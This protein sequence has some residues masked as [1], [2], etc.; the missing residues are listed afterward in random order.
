MF[1][2]LDGR[3]W[4]EDWRSD[5]QTIAGLTK[6]SGWTAF[7]STGRMLGRLIIPGS[8]SVELRRF[9]VGFGK[10][11]VIFNRLDDDGALHYTAYRSR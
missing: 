11:E 9:V 6:P 2:D 10:D 4:V 7:D 1:V 8:A 3:L 5:G